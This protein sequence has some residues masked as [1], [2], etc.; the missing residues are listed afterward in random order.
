MTLSTG[1]KLSIILAISLLWE[2]LSIYLA[3]PWFRDLSAQ[4]STWYAAF[5]IGG[6][7]LI[8]GWAVMFFILCLLFDKRKKFDDVHNEP[9]TILVAAYNESAS[10]VN[11]LNSIEAQRYNKC[12]RVL[13]MD[14]GSTDGTADIAAKWKR[15][16]KRRYHY[17]VVRI[18][19]NA[20]KSAAL[21]RGLAMVDT[22]YFITLDGDSDLHRDAVKNIMSNL[23]GSGDEYA[24]TAGL[25][26]VKNKNVNW[27]TK[28]QYYDYLFGIAGSK[29][30]QS[31]LEGTLVAQGAFSAYQ[32]EVIRKL[33]GWKEVVGEDIVLTW[34]MLEL[35]YKVNHAE[36]AVVYTNVP[37]KTKQY[38][39]QRKRWARGL[40]EAFKNHP[41]TIIKLKK[42]YP[43]I[44]NNILLPIMDLA[45]IFGLLPGV[46]LALVFQK[47]WIVGLFSLLV[48]PFT[49]FMLFMMN[50][51]QKSTLNELGIST[52]GTLLGLFF[53]VFV[54]QFI[55]SFSSL[56][57]YVDEIFSRAKVW[58]TK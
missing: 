51:V 31:F 36:N 2:V 1:K 49:I 23:V 41:R 39:K 24:A 14:D 22:K 57:G 37:E 8:P 34:G 43:F 16:K 7:A 50:R 47:F 9:V 13:V 21:N 15:E 45:I 30:T 52:R 6:V 20:G 55:L 3:I 17:T 4:I 44:F 58:G 42:N 26:L 10:I 56:M 40:I 54:Y 48:L 18:K 33:G 27:L 53:F 12:I 35:G 29:R 25:V 38:F 28:V 5:V 11:T 46:I 19:K 32:T